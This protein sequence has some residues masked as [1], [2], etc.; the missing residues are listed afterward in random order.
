MKTPMLTIFLAAG[1]IAGC[2]NRT[3]QQE[4]EKQDSV[5]AEK[6]ADS[7]LRSATEGDTLPADK[8]GVDTAGIDSVIP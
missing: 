3:A 2:T 7:L 4:Q 8:T 1:I 5:A 6:A